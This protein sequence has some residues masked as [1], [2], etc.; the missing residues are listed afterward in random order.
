MENRLIFLCHLVFVE[1]REDGEGY[2]GQVLDVLVE[3]VGGSLRIKTGDHSTL[4]GD[5]APMLRRRS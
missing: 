5:A 4:R 3:A 1:T 2:T